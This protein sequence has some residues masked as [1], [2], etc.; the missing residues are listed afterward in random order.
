M[1][2]SQILS[3]LS[4]VVIT[5]V[6]A[7]SVPTTV[8]YA[9][10]GSKGFRAH[11]NKSS[12]G[13][14]IVRMSDE[15][16]A[17]YTGKVR[18]Y[19]A[20]RPA[21]GEKLDASRPEVES[22]RGYLRSRH[23]D[24][25]AR[26]GGRKIY[27]YGLVFNGFAAELTEKQ[28]QKLAS[29]PGVLA[30]MKDELRYSDTSTTPA[31]L[32]LNADD[33]LWDRLDSPRDAGESVVVGIIDSGIWPE[34]ASFANDAERDHGDDRDHGRGHAYGNRH[35]R[36][37]K[38]TC[39]S[40]EEFVG[41]KVC[42]GK[43]IGARYFNE[44]WGGDAGI[45]ADRPW[46]FNSPRDYDGHGTH[47]AATAAGNYRTKVTGPAAAYG[48]VSGMAPGAKIATYKALWASEDGSTANGFTSDLVAAIDQ[49]VADGVDVINYSVSGT[50]TNFRDAVEIAF[51]YA[52]DAG[53]FVAAS[54][55]NSGPTVGTVAH[56][57]P[58]ITTVAA[59]THN[60]SSIVTA[61]LGNGSTY[62]GA[63]LT[64]AAV[65]APLIDS[66]AAGMAG[67]SATAVSLCYSTSWNGGVA[68]L[69]PAKVAGKIVVCDRGVSDRVDKSLAVQEA[70]GV[71]MILLNPTAN[72]LN[73]DFHSVPTAHLQNTDYATVHAYAA[74]PGA[75]ATI[76]VSTIDTSTPAP[77]IASFSSRGP[78]AAGAGDLLKPDITA[79]GQDILAAVSPVVGGLDF[80]LLS[81]TSMSSPHIAGLAALLKDLYPKWTPMMIKSALMTT[82]GDVLDGP[83]T[84][85]LVIFRQGAGH[86]AP[87][88]AADPG[89][90][91][92]SGWNDWLGFLCGT[93]LPAVNCTSAGIPVLDPSNF[94]T[95]SIA[96]GDLVG[97]QTVT[98]TVTNVDHRRA[99]Y[100]V[101][102]SGLAGLTVTVSPA[103][104][105]INP[106]KSQQVSIT[107]QTTTATPNAY[108]GGQITWSD[109]KHK[110]RIPVV[111]RPLALAAPTQVSGNY[112][113]KFGY[114][115][116]FTAA[117]R[118]LVP[119]TTVS[120]TVAIDDYN[121]HVV[122][123]PAGTTYTRFSLFDANSSADSDLDLEVYNSAFT[124]IGG[125]GGAT[126]AEEVSFVNLTPGTYYVLVVGYAAPAPTADY[127]LFT[128]QLGSTDVGNMT[129]TAPA[130]AVTGTS[131]N[132]GLAFPGPLVPGTKYLGSVAYGGIAGM[133]NPTIVRVDP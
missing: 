131:G 38:G 102:V 120:D 130:T 53:V 57:S 92:K 96:I 10:D 47:T 104:F 116:P 48:R 4:T 36:G 18:G 80:N 30:V 100:N 133:P 82:A 88:K 56:P 86:V 72:T 65:T 41:K 119:A 75:T 45:D 77:Y 128:W 28:A 17:A 99:T 22:Y 118:G 69:D 109:G 6:A 125:S 44:A 5:A 129:V 24:A 112:S 7:V 110:V 39:V 52:A 103:T 12:N 70:G 93:Q 29:M 50:T 25:V 64:T 27:S 21:E 58:W 42:N 63:G 14:Y 105:T 123:V 32:G 61:T 8:T 19:G 79:P 124:L 35:I 73:A 127:T 98:R 68:A 87:N 11:N 34:N 107:F 126:S 46:E 111:V 62:T 59:G 108:V 54:A 121:V 66:T 3:L 31:F 117:A 83:N 33:G 122:S 78:L 132:I 115:G 67:A 9:G 71:G 97:T 51:M 40:G 13:V 114:D 76:G 49:A 37:W 94:N 74:I 23:A 43:I 60:R 81:G 2:R 15:P 85:P 84:H 16:A 26:V 89:L 113:V 55:G 95:P 90:V 91:F 1:R 101:S 106:G 20:T